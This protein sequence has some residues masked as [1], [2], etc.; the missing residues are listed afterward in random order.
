MRRRQYPSEPIPSAGSAPGGRSVQR[1]VWVARLRLA[2]RYRRLA[3]VAAGLGCPP[4]DMRLAYGWRAAV[5]TAAIVAALVGLLTRVTLT[6]LFVAFVSGGVVPVTGF[7]VF[8]T[9]LSVGT[10]GLVRARRFRLAVH[11]RLVP[12]RRRGRRRLSRWGRDT[13]RRRRRL[14]RWFACLVGD[15]LGRARRRLRGRLRR[16]SYRR[17][18]TRR[19]VAPLVALVRR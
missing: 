5:V 14:R 15:R 7:N 17:A 6:G 8:V 1:R 16:A 12:V 19:R 3:S 2:A 9:L 18:G 10:F 11:H 13:R 4:G